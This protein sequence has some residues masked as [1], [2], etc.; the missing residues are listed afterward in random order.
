MVIA[1]W[2][3]RAQKRFEFREGLFDRIEVGTIRREKS[4]ARAHA[5]NRGMDRRL[6]VDR[7]VVQDDDIAGPER[8]HE[9]LLDVGQ[10]RWVVDRPVEDGGRREALEAQRRDDR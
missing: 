7:E 1:A 9:H 2:A 8:G 3:Q 6:F 4:D 5:R 10:E